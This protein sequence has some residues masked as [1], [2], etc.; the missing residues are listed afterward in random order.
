VHVKKGTKDRPRDWDLD[1]Q[2]AWSKRKKDGK[3]R[4]EIL[5]DYNTGTRLECPKCNRSRGAK[6]PK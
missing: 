3:S 1:H 5:D 6:T 4:K 2:P